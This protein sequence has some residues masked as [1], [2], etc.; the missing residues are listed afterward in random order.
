MQAVATGAGFIAEN[1]PGP[2]CCQQ[3]R[4]AQYR[5]GG[6]FND[7]LEANFPVSAFLSGG[8]C[9]GISMNV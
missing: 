6:V 8:N 9:N 7:A 1:W 5:I 2:G 3:L 4:Q